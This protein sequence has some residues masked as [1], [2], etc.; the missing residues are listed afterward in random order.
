MIYLISFV[1]FLSIFLLW[2]VPKWQLS[3]KKYTE[4]EE[5]KITL[6]NELRKTI[7]QIIGGILV[8]IGLGFTYE[9]ISTTKDT[10]NISQERLKTDRYSKAID[11][12]GSDKS[13]VRLGGIF[14]LEKISESSPDYASVINKVLATYIRQKSNMHDSTIFEELQ[15]AIDIISYKDNHKNYERDSIYEVN[16]SNVILCRFDF[17]NSILKNAKMI[18]SD[19]SGSNFVSANLTRVTAYGA[20]FFKTNLTNANLSGSNFYGGNFEQAIFSGSI[21]KNANFQLADLKEADFSNCDLS[22]VDLTDA[23]LTGTKLLG[24][25]LLKAI[26]LTKEQIHSARINNN[27]K[28]SSNLN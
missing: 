2:Q 9:Q 28:I 4:I 10:I 1:F 14:A 21:L 27:T 22:G 13:Q 19:F 3:K 11:Q 8:L 23:D 15:A 7:A 6:E 18:A 24:A 26:G 12:L 16:I 20:N 17:N 5:K 25:N